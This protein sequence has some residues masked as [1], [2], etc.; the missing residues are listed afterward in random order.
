M[1]LN[2]KMELYIYQDID[3]LDGDHGVGHGG[4]G[5]GTVVVT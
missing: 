5:R 4:G 2:F 1:F 3:L